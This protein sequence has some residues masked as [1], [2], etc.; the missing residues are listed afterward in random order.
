[1][2][3][4][5]GSAK[6]VLE[7]KGCVSELVSFL[8]LKEDSSILGLLVRDRLLA[9]CFHSEGTLFPAYF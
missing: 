9:V 1:M 3:A 5:F 2:F 8:C 6:V 7:F 4:G